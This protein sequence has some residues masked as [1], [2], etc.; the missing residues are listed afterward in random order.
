MRSGAALPVSANW[1][2]VFR[3]LRRWTQKEKLMQRELTLE[4]VSFRQTRDAFDVGRGEHLSSDD[5][6]F[7]VGRIS[8][9]GLHD[10]VAECLALRVGPAAVQV[11]RRVLDEDAHHV[12][13][14]WRHSGID[15]RWDDDVHVWMSRELSV[16]RVIVR[17][18]EVFDAWTDR[19]RATQVRADAGHAGEVR[20][21]TQREVHLTGRPAELVS[22]HCFNEVVRQLLAIDELEKGAPRV[23][24]GN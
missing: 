18:L 11:I 19:E 16:L 24:A 1:R 17:A 12:L 4:D 20:Q 13:P 8:R 7:D 3:P 6:R 22:L 2:L 10:G 15:H 23:E 9:E 21:P 14:W 5:Q